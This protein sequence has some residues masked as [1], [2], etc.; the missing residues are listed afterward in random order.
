MLHVHKYATTR[1]FISEKCLGA[2]FLSV[3]LKL[4]IIS[5]TLLFGLIFL[6]FGSR[7]SADPCSNFSEVVS[8]VSSLRGLTLKREIS[9]ITTSRAEFDA[10]TRAIPLDRDVLELES[11]V[12]KSL[13]IIPESFDYAGCS[14]TVSQADALASYSPQ[15]KSILVPEN[16]SS[17]LGLL[18][19]EI[20]HALQDQHFDLDSVRKDASFTTDSALALDALI[21][22]DAVRIER[23]F[24]AGPVVSTPPQL[25]YGP[26]DSNCALP[27]IFL[28]QVDLSYFF[29]P[30]FVDTL[31]PE[32]GLKVLFKHPPTTSA[33]I[34]HP[35]LY[36]A[37]Q[38]A[39][40][41][42]NHLKH[43]NVLLRDRLGEFMIRSLL[44]QSMP[45][46]LAIDAASGWADD[47][48]TLRRHG[49]KT[50]VLN[51]NTT[52]IST[53]DRDQFWDAIL[54][55]FARRMQVP[56]NSSTSAVQL[57]VPN[58][59]PIRFQRA[60]NSVFLEIELS[61]GK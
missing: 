26:A 41:K 61:H 19:H 33:E 60:R 8:K 13:G 43:R 12:F 18:A 14:Q 9:C 56:I 50:L 22:G 11:I 53:H 49:G 15:K 10:Q 23:L 6:F 52:W 27:E 57:E 20:V 30:L 3:D 39:A 21:E 51:W 32:V 1:F 40:P 42:F 28:A 45:A 46:T 44:K 5:R 48:L 47:E 16:S 55:V 24:N 37:D 7:V 54:L 29:G 17:S 25:N 35:K 31:Q 4:R 34:L 36:R 38:Q 59:A 2:G 58:Y